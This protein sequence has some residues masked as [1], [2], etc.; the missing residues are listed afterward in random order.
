VLSFSEEFEKVGKT[1]NRIT[2]L[3]LRFTRTW[4]A[5][6][7]ET[8]GTGLPIHPMLPSLDQA[9]RLLNFIKRIVLA[10]LT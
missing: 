5:E 1:D 8:S 4:I 3:S 10:T 9:K 7:P 6:G 2:Q